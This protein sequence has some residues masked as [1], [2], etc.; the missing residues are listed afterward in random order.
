MDEYGGCVSCVRLYFTKRQRKRKKKENG[1]TKRGSE[2]KTGYISIIFYGPSFLWG[3]DTTENIYFYTF[4]FNRFVYIV[5]QCMWFN[6]QCVLAYLELVNLW[7]HVFSLTARY[8]FFFCVHV[9]FYMDMCVCFAKYPT[10]GTFPNTRVWQASAVQVNCK[11]IN[12]AFFKYNT[13]TYNTT[14]KGNI[15]IYCLVVCR[16]FF[17]PLHRFV[18]LPFQNFFIILYT[19]MR[20]FP[21]Y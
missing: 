12:R 11:N 3:N 1:N 18:T 21:S 4:I 15:S 16:Q 17:F 5:C 7:R 13:R 10:N 6:S 14:Q 9:E 19:V 2:K 20:I 8:G